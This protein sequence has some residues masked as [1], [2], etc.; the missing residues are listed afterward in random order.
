MSRTGAP[1]LRVGHTTDRRIHDGGEDR[2]YDEPGSGH[3]AEYSGDLSDRWN[4]DAKECE[5]ASDHSGENQDRSHDTE[6]VCQL[7]H[8]DEPFG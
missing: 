7:N 1:A 8:D 6:R 2:E 4:D 3:G 5:P